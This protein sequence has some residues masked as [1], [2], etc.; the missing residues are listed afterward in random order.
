MPI[1][2]QRLF[3]RLMKPADGEGGDLGGGATEAAIEAIGT[4]P[5]DP[6]PTDPPAADEPH[7]DA[8]QNDAGAASEGGK[9]KLAAMLDDLTDD[10][11][12]AKPTDKPAAGAEAKPADTPAAKAE[13]QPKA[14]EQEEAE[15]LEGVK[16]ERGKERIKQVFAEKK[17]MEKDLADF[18]Q[19]VQSTGMTPQD[20]AQTLEFGRLVNSGDEKSLRLAL[21]MVEGQRAML[22]Q[23]LGV[24]A[25]G[26]DLLTG[27]DDLKAAVENME[28]TRERAVELA[29]YRKQQQE[30][31]QRQQV[32][33]QTVQERQQF[34]QQVQQA[35][36]SMEAYLQTRAQEVDHPARMKVITDHFKNPDNLQRFVSTFKPDQWP[37]AIQMMYDNIQVQRPASAPQPIRSR[38]ATLGTP[39]AS[40]AS[41][42]DRVAQRLESMGL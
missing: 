22:Y 41:P 5:A 27:H 3:S 37:A 18:R 33:Q 42:I 30:V 10:P 21:E 4:E 25:P 12:A 20:F 23:K 16:S 8:H 15:L 13:D 28:I 32:E 34:Q 39:A 2:K 31:Q 11:N 40:A 1:W 14:P 24:E 38:P 7:Q 9:S 19:M 35:A 36:G 17:A 6:T 29:K 26:V